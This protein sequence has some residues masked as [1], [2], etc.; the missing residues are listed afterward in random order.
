VVTDKVIKLKLELRWM[1]GWM[2]GW[3]GWIYTDDQDYTRRVVVLAMKA[4]RYTE[5]SRIDTRSSC[6]YIVDLYFTINM[7]VTVIKQQP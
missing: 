3:D 4:A 2:D 1:D 5:N 7:V 6:R